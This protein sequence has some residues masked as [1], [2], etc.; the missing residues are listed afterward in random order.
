MLLPPLKHTVA[1][2]NKNKIVAYKSGGGGGCG[3]MEDLEGEGQLIKC[4]QVLSVHSTF[5]LS[6]RITLI[7]DFFFFFFFFDVHFAEHL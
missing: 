7:D 6:D 5:P 2:H 3:D 1:K 4:C